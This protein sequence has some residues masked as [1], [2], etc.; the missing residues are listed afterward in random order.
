MNQSPWDLAAER[1]RLVRLVTSDVCQECQGGTFRHYACSQFDEEREAAGVRLVAIDA[2]LD[3]D[4]GPVRPLR[5][6]V[7]AIR[8]LVTETR[9]ARPGVRIGRVSVGA[10][11][12]ALLTDALGTAPGEDPVVCGV[13]VGFELLLGD[14]GVKV[15]DEALRPLA[16]MFVGPNGLGA[17]EQETY[18]QLRCDG[19][20]AERAA[21]LALLVTGPAPAAALSVIPFQRIDLDAL[22]GIPAQRRSAAA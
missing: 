5:D 3:A 9:R 4:L 12:H 19:T 16:T 14:D 17:F 1:D 15:L 7:P 22:S 11:T 20:P 2:R 8:S 10:R 13:Q 6:L 18:S 21:E